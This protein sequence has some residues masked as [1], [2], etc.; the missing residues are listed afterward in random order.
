MPISADSLILTYQRSSHIRCFGRN[1]PRGSTGFPSA[2]PRLPVTLIAQAY[3]TLQPIR[4]RRSLATFTLA[5]LETHAV[6][7]NIRTIIEES[8]TIGEWVVE[9]GRRGLEAAI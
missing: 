6:G 9:A 4:S 5:S 2:S 3:S 8:K 1:I 7:Q